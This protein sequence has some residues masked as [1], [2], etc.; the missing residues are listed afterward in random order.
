MLMTGKN[1]PGNIGALPLSYREAQGQPT[2]IRTRN[3]PLIN[4]SNLDH[5]LRHRA[6]GEI[7][8]RTAWFLK[9][10]PLP[11][12]YGSVLAVWRPIARCSMAFVGN[13]R[14]RRGLRTRTVRLLKPSPL[15]IGLD[16]RT[17]TGMVTCACPSAL[18]AAFRSLA[19]GV[20]P[21][22]LG[23]SNPTAIADAGR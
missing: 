15:P 6:S 19:L 23:E 5:H 7:R 16:E 13:A 22:A 9:P 18:M 3:L 8:T 21:F 11:L 10:L 14:A 12:G 17:S 1:R 4:G 2:G 20:E